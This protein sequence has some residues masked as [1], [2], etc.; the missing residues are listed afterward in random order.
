MNCM[1]CGRKIENNG[2]FCEGCLS[3]MEKYPVKQNAT[4][5][6]PKN[7]DAV[8]PKKSNKKKHQTP[9]EDQVNYQRRVIRRL[10][11]MV[12]VLFLAV[13]LLLG[14]LLYE[15]VLTPDKEQNNTGKNYTTV[16]PGAK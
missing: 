11:L 14:W 3:V 13:S 2:V 15:T 10:G 8:A 7:R 6:L 5:Q 1:K 16:A 9:L 4:L 12:G